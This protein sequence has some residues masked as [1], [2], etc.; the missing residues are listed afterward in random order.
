MLTEKIYDKW[1]KETQRKK[2]QEILKQV[3]VVQPVLDIGCGPG[4]LEEFIEAVATDIDEENLAKVKGKKIL[5]DGNN[6]P[7]EPESFSTIFCIDT[8]H[9]IKEPKK[10]LKF[11]KKDGKLIV[12]QFCNQHNH[13]EKLLELKNK[14][15]N[16]KI[17]KEFLIKTEKE[18]ETVLVLSNNT[19]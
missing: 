8:I 9:F 3:E 6:L 17:E 1:M 18:W 12:G 7:F 13:K 2:I 14:F 15:S 11:L 19:F 4:F 16:I 10:L 5:A